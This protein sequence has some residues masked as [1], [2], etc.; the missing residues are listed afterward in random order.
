MEAKEE[1]QYIQR[2][3]D[4]ETELYAV[5]L[6]RYSRSIYLLIVQMVS[7]PEDAEELVQDT[8][9]KAFRSLGR[10]KGESRFSTWLYRIAY[11]VTISFIRKKRQEFLYIEENTI[12]N[13]PDEKADEVL[14]PTDDEERIT[15]LVQAIE[16]LN[17][18]EKAVITLFYYE[19]KSIEEVG[20]V[21]NLTVS[22]VKV[23]L[24][25]I[26]KKLYLLMSK[27][28]DPYR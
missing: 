28:D 17:A 3:L 6:D 18:E 2:I 11:N 15:A 13:V 26:R 4:G 19:E 9:L 1:R 12:N 5:L 25:R 21:L 10:Y 7:H 23:R 14:C 20:E 24:H 8:F 16:L 22:N 27:K